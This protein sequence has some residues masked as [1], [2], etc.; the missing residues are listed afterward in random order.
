MKNYFE[1]RANNCIL[2]TREVL[3]ELPTFSD[4]FFV[5]VEQSTS[6]LTR[7]N[8]AYDLRVFFEYLM[9]E[10]D[11]FDKDLRQL[12][13][14]D[15]NKISAQTIENFLSYLSHY[16]YD[17]KEYSNGD[18]GKS[19]K[20]STIKTFFSY[21]YNKGFINENVTQ[22][23]KMPKLHEKPIIKLE[24]DEIAKLITITEAGSSLTDR[25]KAFHQYT[26]ERDVAIITLM[27]G[28]G[29]R[30]SECVGLNLEDIDFDVNGIKITRKG[31]NQE[32]VYFGDEVRESLL[33]YLVVRNT[34]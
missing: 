12:H 6:P 21:F 18:Q 30:V 27:L 1:A 10:T 16:S 13:P 29:I 28:T 14:E 19:R 7:L 2:K 25:E 11:L 22:K 9:T 15:L 26:K 3:K 23:V 20:L 8:Y 4:M 5:G 34:Q 31:G 24:A 17:N 32:I 33:S